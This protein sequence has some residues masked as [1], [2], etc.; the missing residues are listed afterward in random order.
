MGEAP[1]PAEQSPPGQTARV[2]APHVD[3]RRA[4][5]PVGAPPQGSSSAVCLIGRI[6]DRATFTRLRRSGRRARRGPVTVTWVA[7]EPT[8]PTRVAYTV[9]RRVGGAVI[10]NRVRR[11]LRAAVAEASPYLRPGPYLIGAG[12]EAARV[13]YRELRA[14]VCEAVIAVVRAP[15]PTGQGRR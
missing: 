15:V 10:R 14:A 12:P 8:E 11:R 13:P 5:H 7:G 2:P 3:P 1:V 6:S 4:G 9:G